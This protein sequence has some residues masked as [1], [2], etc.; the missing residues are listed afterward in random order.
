MSLEGAMAQSE[1]DLRS[2]AGIVRRIN[3]DV[4]FVPPDPG[5]IIGRVL[6][7]GNA[8]SKVPTEVQV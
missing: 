7:V 6:H 2:R 3:V 4:L 1:G 8:T 5:L